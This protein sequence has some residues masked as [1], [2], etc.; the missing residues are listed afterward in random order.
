MSNSIDKNFSRSSRLGQRTILT[1]RAMLNGL[2]GA[3]AV[4]IGLPLLNCMLNDNGNAFADGVALP[5]R[6]GTFFWGLG[7]S[8][9]QWV[10]QK[11]GMDW[12]LPESLTAFEDLRPYLTLITGTNHQSQLGGVGH[13]GGV[14]IAL[15][16][17]QDLSGFGRG[18]NP[19]EP[20]IDM[21]IAETLKGK[22]KFDSLEVG[23]CRTGPYSG[24]SSWGRGG[25][26]N[27]SEPSPQK[28]FDRIFGGGVPTASTPTVVDTSNSLTETSRMLGKSALD[29]VLGDMKTLK[30]Q[31]GKADSERLDQHFEGLRSIERRLSPSSGN[32]N[33]GQTVPIVSAGC[34]LPT[35]TSRTDFGDGSAKEDKAAKS[36]LM[37]D[38]IV[39]ALAC[40]L[41][42]IFSYEWSAKQ[43][44]TKYWE[45]NVD[46]SHH[47][48]V[49]HTN[50]QGP[51]MRRIVQFIMS[52]LAKMAR[53]MAAQKEGA[54]NILDNTLILG[55]SE[56]ANSGAHNFTD[57]PYILVGKAGGKIRAGQ[58]YRDTQNGNY[59]APRVLFTVAKAMGSP[60]TSIGQ[61]ENGR[62]TSELIPGILT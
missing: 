27:S 59:N 11:T 44:E 42:R 35:R 19:P 5:L 37:S 52:N 47:E 23:I 26:H 46:A 36:D 4:S 38:L 39:T 8:H 16:S 60:V 9:P 28:V 7:V 40:D 13:I 61:T 53:K 32:Q 21:L 3:S 22:T 57:H 29:V 24:N 45:V 34:K 51:E 33:P 30:A 14:G 25:A 41:T 43:S 48:G 62:K 20:S 17:S 6:F 15:S 56:H 49:S 55:S 1:R 58:H 31:V 2:M 12:A 18:Q 54:G 10:P 50:S